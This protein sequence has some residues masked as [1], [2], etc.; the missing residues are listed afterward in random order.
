MKKDIALL[1][2]R[3]AGLGLAL[4]HGW[5]KI[6][7]L[8]TGGGDRFIAGVGA[9]GVPLPGVFAWAAAISEF[10][11][12]LLVVLGLGTRIAAS[13]A[14]F[15]MFVAAFFRHRFHQ[16]ILVSLGLL[17]ASPDEVKK[18]GNPEMGLI[19]MVCF[20]AIVLMG[21]GRFSLDRLSLKRK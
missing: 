12:G 19:Y 20:L 3:L 10:G 9:L 17:S 13:F 4:G 7:S 14:A 18:W 1:L 11:C 16:H 8:A 5:G 21:G 2:L 15:T 6:S